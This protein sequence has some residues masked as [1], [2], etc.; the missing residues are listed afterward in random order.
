MKKRLLPLLLTLALLLTLSV[1]A[2]ADDAARDTDAVILFTSDVHCGIDQG[3]G[4]A[5][6]QQVRDSLLARGDDVILVDDGDNIQG[7]PIGTMTKGEALVDLMNAMGYSVAITENLGGVI[8]EE[9]VD[10][11]GQDRIVIVEEAP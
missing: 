5:G 10:L 6:L 8:G 7:E 1:T 2:F 11:T 9:Y 4:Y 3:F